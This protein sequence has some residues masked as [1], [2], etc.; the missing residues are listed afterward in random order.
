MTLTVS[1]LSLLRPP[2]SRTADANDLVN[3]VLCCF[4]EGLFAG[5]EEAIIDIESLAGEMCL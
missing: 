1:I 4:A 3:V 2:H 5:M